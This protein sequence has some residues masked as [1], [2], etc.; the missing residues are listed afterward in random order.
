MNHLPAGTVTLLFTDIEGSTRLLQQL[1]DRYDGVLAEC[2]QAFRSGFQAYGGY[3]VDTQGDAFLVAFARATDAVLAAVMIQRSLANH[4]WPG[5]VLVQARI[6]L[7]TGEPRLASEGY[8]GLDVHHAAR[9]MNA[10]HGGQVL[11]SQTTRDLVEHDLPEGV[12]LRDRG[13]HRRKDLGRKSHLFQLVIDGMPADFPPL[14]TLVAHPNNLPIQP[15]P[16]VGREQDVLAVKDLLCHEQVCLVTLTGP[17][18]VGK[19]RLSLQVAAELTEHFSDGIF[20]VSLAPLSDPA[21]VVPTI[22]R[23]LGIREAAGYSLLDRLKE[24]LQQ[25]QQLLL[26]DNFEQVVSASVQVAD[27]LTVC[28]Q[29]K[30]LVTSRQVL[31]VHA[32]HEY[33]VPPLA[34]PDLTHLPDPA[35]LAHC[36]AVALFL[37]RAQSVKP[38]F[39][40]TDTN[41]RAVAEICAHLD[42]LPLAI[43]LATARMKL[44]PLQAL[45]ARLGQR[46]T[47][48]TSGARDAPV[49][50]QTL[51][52]TIEWS[53]HLLDPREQRLFRRL[54]IFVGGCTLTSIE[55][56]CKALNDDAE[57]ILDGV[58]S[59]IDK[60]LLLHIEQEGQEP[61]L[62]MLETIR[63][64]GLET[65][66]ASGEMESTRKAHAD[67]YVLLAEE[68]E[69][70]LA[71]AQ[72]V[73]WLKR[74][75]REHDNL[76]AAM[77]WSLERGEAGKRIEKALQLGGVLER[78]WVV[79]GHRSEGR[80]FLAEVLTRSAGEKTPLRAKALIAAAR[81]AFSQ[82]RYEQGEALAQ[83][84]RAL[85][86]ELG[87]RRGIALSLDRLGMAAWRRG[88]FTMARAL[89]E[90]DLA[91]FREVGD[92]QRVA[93]SLFT[94]ALLASKQ[95]EYSRAQILLG[96]SLALHR[97]LGNTRG[98]AASLSQL[99]WVIF[100]SRGDKA[101]V[102]TLLE[103]VRTL[104][105]EVGDK[106]GLAVSCTL[107]AWFALSQG[108]TAAA[109]SLVEEGLI[110]YRE[111]GHQEGTAESLTM[112]ARV[113]AYQG[114]Y[115]TARKLYEESLK[116]AQDMDDKE[117]IA[118]SLEGLAVVAAVQGEPARA[119]RLWGAA[120]AL[121]EVIGAPLPP[122]ERVDYER[123]VAKTRV[124]LGEEA[125]TSTWAQGRT[126]T[127]DHIL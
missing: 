29:L 108:N 11:L 12:R 118:S 41:A 40:L 109:R 14:R 13:E 44:L 37:Q 83:E 125:F 28:S 58:A 51:R 68:A 7:H 30:L 72:Q 106:E 76:R 33:A 32:E 53:Y 9:I 65:L 85:F 39:A 86:R 84:G 50:Q 90:E 52:N 2:R 101:R 15:T 5:G 124:Q 74:L 46:L 48:L 81:L 19:T 97:T 59:L 82:N 6:G 77:Q 38:E 25:K 49:R 21:L 127:P 98:I 63:E 31:H 55:A 123:L 115:A 17:G 96:E 47:L 107:S 62:L 60:S 104:N 100:V 27:L 61:R 122:I 64:Y 93:W 92:Q 78:F 45:L 80:A 119:A 24:E 69:P 94:L 103:E 71:G 22:A 87:D 75:E 126:M 116:I 16:L 35:T 120:E 111:M 117:L 95:G 36:P 26:L 1:G 91:L 20:F 88:N 23:T 66:A 43:E 3:E 99:A 8:I 110:L 56:V 112:L 113:E 34:M 57:P 114:N 73:V 102:S 79:R 89:M 105:R 54:A 4:P 10:G 18:G 67:Y 70:E 42:G 121:R